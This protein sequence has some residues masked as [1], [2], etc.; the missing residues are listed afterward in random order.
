MALSLLSWSTRVL[1]MSSPG[2]HSGYVFC[3][4]DLILCLQWDTLFFTSFPKLLC[5][6]TLHWWVLCSTL[7]VGSFWWWMKGGCTV[8]KSNLRALWMKSASHMKK[9]VLSIVIISLKSWI[10]KGHLYSSK[11]NTQQHAK[12]E[13]K[14]PKKMLP[15]VISGSA[16]PGSIN[17]YFVVF[18]DLSTWAER[19]RIGRQKLHCWAAPSGLTPSTLAAY[20]LQGDSTRAGTTCRWM[21]Q[22]HRWRFGLVHLIMI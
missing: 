2:S 5:T 19:E 13:L 6:A 15:H 11:A 17:N 7:E 16:I 4:L 18:T 1:M 3:Q 9:L 21:R 20:L 14:Q 12:R 10:W 22:R 8:L